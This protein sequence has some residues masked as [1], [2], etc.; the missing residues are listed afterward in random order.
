MTAELTASEP[1]M[2]APEVCL[3]CAVRV[4]ERNGAWEHASASPCGQPRPC[5]PAERD[6]RWQDWRDQHPA[7]R[8]T[9][10]RGGAAHIPAYGVL[11][12]ALCGRNLGTPIPAAPLMP[13]CRACLD[14][15]AAADYGWRYEQ[16]WRKPYGGTGI[17]PLVT[18]MGLRPEVEPQ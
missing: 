4:I 13:A 2:R 16:S 12:L 17:A 11:G 8:A 1:L 6:L 7:V 15:H 5:D 14:W 10:Q 9:G 3:Y 18:L